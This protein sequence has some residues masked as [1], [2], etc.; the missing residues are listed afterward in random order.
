MWCIVYKVGNVTTLFPERALCAAKK[1]HKKVS[2]RLTKNY[3]NVMRKQRAR[4]LMGMN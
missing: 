4:E 3:N 1:Q 2:V